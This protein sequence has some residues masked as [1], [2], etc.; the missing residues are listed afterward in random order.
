MSRWLRFLPVAIL[1]L[2]VAAMVWRL[3]NP[4]DTTIRSQ[5]IGKPVP[6]FTATAALPGKPGVGPGELADGRVKLVNF[7]ASWCAPCIAEA[8]VLMELKDRGVPIVGIA[9]RDRPEDLAR[10]LVGNGDPFERI[11]A[12]RESKVQLAFGSGGVPETFVVDGR[13][14]IRLHHAGPI[15]PGDMPEILQAV[16]AAR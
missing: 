11:G 8:P 7:F 4:P 3:A 15:E 13:G 12:D 1:A 6:R 5:L 9:V 2:L 10:F 16:E 14:I